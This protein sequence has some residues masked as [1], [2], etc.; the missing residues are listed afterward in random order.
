MLNEIKIEVSEPTHPIAEEIT[1][2]DVWGKWTEDYQTQIHKGMVVANCQLG[3][4]NKDK[5]RSNEKCPIFKTYIP[6]KSATIV[7]PIELAEQVA[8]WL[9]Y[10]HG[11]DCISKVKEFDGKIAFR[12]DYMAW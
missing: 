1:Q 12:S 3:G 2:E 8:Y 11:A 7:A 4:M 10:N 5:L 6:W 9:E